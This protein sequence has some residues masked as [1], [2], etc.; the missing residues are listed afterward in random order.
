V[1]S[2]NDILPRVKRN[3]IESPQIEISLMGSQTFGSGGLCTDPSQ[4]SAEMMTKEN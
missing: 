1:I 3:L 2:K 4:S